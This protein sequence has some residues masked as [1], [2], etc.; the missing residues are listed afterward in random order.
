MDRSLHH[1]RLTYI[2]IYIDFYID[3]HIYIYIDIGQGSHFLH[4]MITGIFYPPSV[5]YRSIMH[6]LLGENSGLCRLSNK[7]TFN[8]IKIYQ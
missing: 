4:H 5:I 3:I 6:L 8:V 2:H 1:V 7:I